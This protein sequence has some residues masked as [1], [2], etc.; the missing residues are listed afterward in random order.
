MPDLD[1]L[2][3]IAYEV[4][5]DAGLSDDEGEA[6]ALDN[7]QAAAWNRPRKWIPVA[8]FHEGVRA[9]ICVPKTSH[10]TGLNSWLWGFR[11]TC[12]T[13]IWR[14]SRKPYA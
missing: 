7:A 10:K 9:V 5:R 12:G 13:I 1:A 6:D 2:R 4:A 14:G 3:K 11:L 8:D